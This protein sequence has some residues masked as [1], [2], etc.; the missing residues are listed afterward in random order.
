MS[1]TPPEDAP[2]PHRLRLIAP[3]AGPQTGSRTYARALVAHLAPEGAT[4]TEDLGLLAAPGAAVVHLLD[5]KSWV[6][7]ERPLPPP[8]GPA[9]VVDLHDAYWLDARPYPAPDR[10]LRRRRWRRDRP[11]FLGLLLRADLVI[12]HARAMTAAVPHRRTAVVPI[13]VEAVSS[14]EPRPVSTPPRVLFAGRDGARK[15]LAVLGAALRHL[16]AGGRRMDLRIAGGDFPHLRPWT[17]W[18]T[19]GLRRRFLGD[20][21]P[22]ALDVAYGEADLVAAPSYTEAFGLVIQEALLRGV[23][24][25]ASAVEGPEEILSEAPGGLTVPSGDPKGLAAGIAS[26]LEDYPE[27]TR[28]A[29]AA[30]DT[31]RATR[32]PERT[33][34]ALTRAYARA[35]RERNA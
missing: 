30:G 7:S 24:V 27:W 35:Q 25:V 6:R 11:R 26:I 16:E 34:T 2:L 18:W 14:R 29:R 9:L 17:R 19:R 32:S 4:V 13:P 33:L 21:S 28:R 23:P 3:P 5:A 10:L 12:V 20:L 22:A 1:A 31:L 15:G 8:G